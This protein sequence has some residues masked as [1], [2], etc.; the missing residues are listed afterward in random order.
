M[1]INS[2][3][4]KKIITF[5][6]VGIAATFTHALLYYI[7][8]SGGLDNEQLANFFAYLPSLVVSYF[9]QRFLTF[10]SH[11]VDSE[12]K[13]ATKFILV[14][15]LTYLL[16]AFWVFVVSDILGLPPEYAILGILFF[17]PIIS[18]VLFEIWVFRHVVSHHR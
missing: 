10:K 8:I 18:F 1:E 13:S 16:N 5:A 4:P 3:I 2:G 11:I 9:G 14:S 12:K 7:F 15:F 6:G 17:T